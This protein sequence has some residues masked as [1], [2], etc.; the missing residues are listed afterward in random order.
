MLNTFYRLS[1]ISTGMYILAAFAFAI[2]AGITRWCGKQIPYGADQLTSTVEW[3]AMALFSLSYIMMWVL[4]VVG[5]LRPRTTFA[6]HGDV[7]SRISNFLLALG[8]LLLLHLLL[9][10]AVATSGS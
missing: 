7:G 2:L 4:L 8:G 3:T 6:R 10:F 1:A 5:P 9:V